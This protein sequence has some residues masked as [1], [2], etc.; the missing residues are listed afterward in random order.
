MGIGGTIIGSPYK[1][2][3]IPWILGLVFGAWF[4][5]HQIAH[6]GRRIEVTGQ[7]ELK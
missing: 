2:L 4:K 6:L 7:L 3:Q 5:T 1:Y